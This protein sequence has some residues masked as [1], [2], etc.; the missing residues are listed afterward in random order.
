MPSRNTTESIIQKF[1]KVHS[2]KYDYSN[3]KYINNR[4][5][6]KIICPIHGM[7]E[8]KPQI[9]LKGCGC[10]FCGKIKNKQPITF[11]TEEVIKRFKYV[12]GD[13]YDYSKVNYIN[14][15]NKLIVICKK[16]GDF[17]IT[18]IAHE[19]YKRGCKKCKQGHYVDKSKID[20]KNLMWKNKMNNIW[21]GKYDFTDSHFSNKRCEVIVKCKL[22]GFF[23]SKVS[24]LN[25][26][27]GGCEHCCENKRQAKHTEKHQNTF[28]QKASIIHKN[29]YD[30]SLV[31]Y[32]NNSTKITI[33]CPKH[34]QFEQV[35]YTHLSGCGCNFCKTS[36]GENKILDFLKKYNIQY[37]PQYFVKINEKNY[38]FDFY[39]KAYNII[40]EFDGKQHFQPIKLFGGQNGFQK[41]IHNDNIKNK[42]CYDNNINLIRIPYYDFNNIDDILI[43]K[44]FLGNIY[45]SHISPTKS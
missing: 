40:I 4:I 13:T 29:K 11:T 32:I 2:K 15:S 19:Y 7:F 12:H 21:K 23:K 16:H 28:I 26:G 24:V 27:R 6:V 41:I 9:H 44:L 36:K 35:P 33:I 30:Y 42:Y 5:N 1:E 43:K 18:R 20:K 31:N 3:V 38:F 37:E 14:S 34:G 25:M 8:Q 39:L 17:L 22:H 45:D 10:R